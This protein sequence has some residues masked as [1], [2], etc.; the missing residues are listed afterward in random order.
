M[1]IIA[2]I[3]VYLCC[4]LM[5]FVKREYKIA[6]LLLSSITFTLV[7]PPVP[8][9]SAPAVLSLCF[10]VSEIPHLIKLI[11]GSRKSIVW[12]ITGIVLLSIIITILSSPHL[13]D[14]NVA[15]YYFQG[16]FLCK[17]LV[18]VYSFWSFK[19]INSLKPTLKVTFWGLIVLT[20]F[21]VFNYLS[22]TAD[23][24]NAMMEGVVS[25]LKGP[26]GSDAGNYFTYADRFRVQ[27]MFS[28]PFDYG[29]I[30]VLM[31]ILH[32]YGYTQHLEKLKAFVVV[33]A[34]TLF[35]IIFCGCRTILFCTLIGLSIYLLLAFKT[36][37]RLKIVLVTLF[38]IPIA[39]QTIPEVQE[40]TDKM[41]TVFN[42][43]SQV[44][45]SSLEMRSVQYATVLLYI[46]DNPWLGRGYGF[47]NQDLGWGE[48]IIVDERLAGMEGVVM[49]LLL[50]HGIIGL[51]L[52]LIYYV[53]LIM[54]FIRNREI[55]K[56]LS[57]LGISLIAVYLSF[58]NMTGELLS[59][60]PTLCCVGFVLKTLNTEEKEL[61][62]A[63]DNSIDSQQHP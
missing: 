25:D 63:I 34:C 62:K 55:S 31:L 20:V 2:I 7:S 45:G 58:A 4:A 5:F 8:H 53:S 23:F 14:K 54:Y 61:S 46:N 32:L 17:Y 56:P 36:Q 12:K 41:L 19:D 24:V 29:Y 47:F 27:A 11:K 50:E 49:S 51:I 30:C 33:V 60:F 57:A 1:K 26:S 40:Q 13:S 39:Y 21:G 37:K 42:K 44:E 48:G 22:K 3:A 38:I 43:N 52:Y 59:V 10:L 16:E 28:N 6:I 15:Y 9:Y 18:L 35:G